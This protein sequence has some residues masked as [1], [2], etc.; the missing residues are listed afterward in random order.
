LTIAGIWALSPAPAF[1]VS[2]EI[3]RIMQQLDTLQQTVQSMQKTIDAQT[4]IIRTLVER[5]SDNVNDMKS[6]V[7]DLQRSS[8]KNLASTDARFDTLTS[9][10]QALSESLE[11]AKARIAKLSDQV[12]KTQNIIQ[13]LNTPPPVQPGDQTAAGGQAPAVPD[14]TT[15]FN[16]GK[17]YMTGGQYDLA[18][19]AFQDFL[20]NYGDTDMAP[21]A[22]YYIAES[23]FAQKNYTQAVREYNTCLERYPNGSVLPTAQLHKSDAL[24][25]LDQ[26]TAAVKELRSLI[27]RFPNTR[28]ADLA[29]Q[30]LKSLRVAVR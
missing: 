9:Q 29:R 23:Y 7:A 30:R 26:K 11:E 6:T 8:Q 20:K 13:T 2:R 10:I 15:L 25:K 28:E 19:Q 16:S 18:I 21:T 27:Q 5:A 17:S 22:Q 12:A 14:P 4:A 1:G 24:L 3:I